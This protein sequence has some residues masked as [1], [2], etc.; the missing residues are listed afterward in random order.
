MLAHRTTYAP[1][2]VRSLRLT[3]R[4]KRSL[5]V[6]PTNATTVFDLLGQQ[7]NDLTFAVTT[8]EEAAQV[9]RERERKLTE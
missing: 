1:S 9:T 7:E 2:A 4:L 5:T 3:G 6:G 8:V